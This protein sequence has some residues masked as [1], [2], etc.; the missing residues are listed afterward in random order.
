MKWKFESE[1]ALKAVSTAGTLLHDPFPPIISEKNHF[2]EIVTELDNTIGRVITHLL[3]ASSKYPVV[4]EE[5]IESYEQITQCPTFWVV[6]PIDGTTNFSTGLP[7]YCSSV[8]LMDR[9][10]FVLGSICSPKTKEIYFTYGDQ[11]SYLNGRLLFIK[12]TAT[13]K[14]ASIAVSFSNS[15]CHIKDHRK[16]Y[17]VFGEIND[18]ARNVLRLGSA[19]L[20]IA[21]VCDGR[22]HGAYGLNA[23]I[24]DVGA[25]LALAK[26]S[27]CS[28]YYELIDNVNVN[29]IVGT[30]SIMND[31]KEILQNKGLLIGD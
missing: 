17:A 12:N 19:A 25:S 28:I 2:K 15:I 5:S 1:L 6:D 20:N 3:S 18:R 29:Y 10:K 22:L 11:G 24:W 23:K 14:Q 21:Y 7:F 30:T 13:L 4:N 9:G 8:G 16:Q 31:I 26:A 27:G